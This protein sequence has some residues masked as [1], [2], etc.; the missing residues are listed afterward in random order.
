MLAHSLGTAEEA[1]SA[2]R[3]I[4]C[5]VRAADRNILFRVRGGWPGSWFTRRRHSNPEL[6]VMAAGGRVVVVK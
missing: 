4:R 3:Q 5:R 6:A 1:F 2:C